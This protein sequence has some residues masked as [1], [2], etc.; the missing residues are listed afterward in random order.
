MGNNLLFLYFYYSQKN[1]VYKLFFC[2]D[3]TEINFDDRP[4]SGNL[5]TF[6]DSHGNSCF[7]VRFKNWAFRQFLILKICWNENTT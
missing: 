4:N 5:E 3:R 1:L 6:E 2:L 7:L